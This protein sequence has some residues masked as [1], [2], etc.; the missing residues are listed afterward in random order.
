MMIRHMHDPSAAEVAFLARPP[1]PADVA[2]SALT[3]GSTPPTTPAHDSEPAAVAPASARLTSYDGRSRRLPPIAR[4]L[5]RRAAFW[6]R[7]PRPPRLGARNRHLPARR[8]RARHPFAPPSNEGTTVNTTL[9]ATSSTSQQAGRR[10]PVASGNDSHVAP[11]WRSWPGASRPRHAATATTSLVARTPAQRRPP[12]RR[13]LQHARC[14]PGRS[15]LMRAAGSRSERP[16]PSPNG[17]PGGPSVTGAAASRQPA[18]G[19]SA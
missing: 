13:E 1:A 8:T 5:P 4:R 12:A 15:D 10:E 11:A 6:R 17:V 19:R 14:S 9:T 7:M 2:R 18:P 16:C 3:A